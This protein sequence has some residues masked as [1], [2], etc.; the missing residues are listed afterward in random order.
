MTHL[1]LTLGVEPLPRTIAGVPDP[2]P[3]DDDPVPLEITVLRDGGEEV[4]TIPLGGT[5]TPV[6]QW[7]IAVR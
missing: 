4:V 7:E 6:P 2:R 3:E 1:R 5:S